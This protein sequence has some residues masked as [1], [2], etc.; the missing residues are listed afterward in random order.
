MRPVARTTR[1]RDASA[2]ADRRARPRPEDQVRTDQRPVEVEREQPDREDGCDHRQRARAGHGAQ[3]ATGR[4]RPA[5]HAAIEARHARQTAR[6]GRP[7]EGRPNRD[8]P[9][10]EEAAPSRSR[11]TMRDP[12]PGPSRSRAGPCR[13]AARTRGRRS[14]S[15][16]IDVEPVGTAVEGPAGL[17]RG[18]DRQPVDLAG[19]DVRE[20]RR[21]HV[22]Q[23]A[24]ER[25]Q[26][27]DRRT[28]CGRRRR[29]RPRSRG[30]AGVRPGRCRWPGSGPRR[31]SGGGAGRRTGRS[32]SSRR[33]CR[34]RPP[35]S[36]GVPAGRGAASSRVDDLGLG[37][38]DDAL[39][40]RARDQRARVGREGEAVE[41]L[42][43]PD[44]GDRLAAL[45]PG[46]VRLVRRGGRLA[47]GRLG[48]G[49][50]PRPVEPDRLAEEQLGVEPRT[51]GAGRPKPLHPDP[52][53][54]LDGRHGRG[55]RRPGL[56]RPHRPRRDRPGARP[57]R[58]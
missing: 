28:G 2:A 37:Q 53:E 10:V 19:R 22:D 30:R 56:S 58:S 45:A 25:Q 38:L 49:D 55:A 16:R 13:R 34:C 7:L 43:A 3:R 11:R 31:A 26:V 51:L 48:V 27:G 39:R 21:E 46:E 36:A 32:R 41:L 29:A 9:A 33:R 44:V 15:A 47:D 57:G 4:I 17:E 5:G 1:P 40:L 35:G 8:G 52:Q 20:V 14:R 12:R 23:L 42:E 24:V 18:G 6:V 54:L 50:D